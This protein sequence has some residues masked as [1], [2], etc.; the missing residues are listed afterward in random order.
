MPKSTETDSTTPETSSST[1][2]VRVPQQ[3]GTIIV[4]TFDTKT[5]HRFTVTNGVIEASSQVD[6][7]LLVSRVDGASLSS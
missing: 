4:T 7:D 6:V 3:D 5:P 1:T 2:K